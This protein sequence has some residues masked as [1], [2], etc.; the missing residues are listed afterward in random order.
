LIPI[1]ARQDNNKFNQQLTVIPELVEGLIQSFLKPFS[2][3]PA[4]FL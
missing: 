1:M 3:D 4:H 2:L